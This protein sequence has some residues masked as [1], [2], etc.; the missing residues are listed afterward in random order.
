MEI[1]LLHIGKH[2][3]N[4][5]LHFNSV[6]KAYVSGRRAMERIYELY[7]N[8]GWLYI[9]IRQP[10]KNDTLCGKHYKDIYIEIHV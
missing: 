8:C 9:W 7:D 3:T 10:L 2:V 4:I 1:T 6:A 5:P